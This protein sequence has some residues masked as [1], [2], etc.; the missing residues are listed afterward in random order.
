M[1]SLC[2]IVRG[3]ARLLSSSTAESALER[4][5][6]DYCQFLSFP[7]RAGRPLLRVRKRRR[8]SLVAS[9]FSS[10]GWLSHYRS[11]KEGRA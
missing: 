8:N 9:G 5:L 4:M 3:A 6:L 2:L 1:T 11:G 10:T 7:Q